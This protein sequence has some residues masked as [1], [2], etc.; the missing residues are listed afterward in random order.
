MAVVGI[1]LAAGQATR[2]GADKLLAKIEGEPIGVMACRHLLAAVPQV[3]AV[4][5]PDD[6]ALAAA[7]DAAGAHV[8]CFA[9]ANDGIGASLAYGVRSTIDAGGWIV[10][11]ADMPWIK[12]AT[13]AR[14]AAAI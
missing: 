8:V 13:I 3:V 9:N 7:L 6:A 1:L 2:F 14:V 4:V 5:R 12:S 10:A 11:L